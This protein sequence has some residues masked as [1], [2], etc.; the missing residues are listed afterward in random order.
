M[1]DRRDDLSDLVFVNLAL[2]SA[3]VFLEYSG[4]FVGVYH[5]LRS[6]WRW[7]RGEFIEASGDRGSRSGGRH[8]DRTPPKSAGSM[9][10]WTSNDFLYKR[11]R[12]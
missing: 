7:I 8:R 9:F 6:F 11:E 5:A 1:L 10:C 12:R 2:D 4:D 3:S